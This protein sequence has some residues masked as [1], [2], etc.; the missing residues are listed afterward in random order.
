MNV[1]VIGGGVIGLSCAW[2]MAQRGAAVSLYDA[3]ALGEGA[4]GAALGALWPAAPLS[5][6]PHQEL[7]R[8][9]LWQFE[10]FIQ[11]LADA[12]GFPVPF[13]RGGRVELLNSSKAA[14]R[15]HE[16]CGAAKARW[17]D[18][19]PGCAVMEVLT[20]EKVAALFPALAARH[21]GA[22][23]CRATA[24]VQIAP[25]LRALEAAC[26][27]AGVTMHWNSPLHALPADSITLVTT[28]AWTQKLLPQLPV[29]PAK[30]QAIALSVPP[31]LHL[32]H[33]VKDGP[34]YLV[35]WDDE[36][37]VGS[38]TEPEAGFDETP[39]LEGRADL[40][41][42]AAAM[43]PELGESRIVRHWAGLRPDGPHHA[44]IIGPLPNQPQTYV[45][46]AFFK[47][48]IGL[49]PRVSTLV[50]QMIIEERVPEELRPFVPANG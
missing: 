26:R 18:L 6:H 29:T 22:L 49:A 7:Q 38:T 34:T 4:S 41:Q 27:H 36:I 20:R 42:R 13:R 10:A 45:A 8:R 3:R 43:F 16:Q 47:T 44:P 50:S 24:Q 1:T 15:A 37:L 19:A 46:T 14:D 48:G 9:S 17:P 23:L 2:R 28:G 31:S 11:E 32:R 12:A 39:T 35:P 25:L 33:I 5:A 30:G 40:H 21:H